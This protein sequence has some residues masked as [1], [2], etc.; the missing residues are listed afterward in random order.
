MDPVKLSTIAQ[1]TGGSLVA[2]K[3]DVAVENVCTDSRKLGIGDLF[4]ALRGE[5]FDA[6]DFIAQAAEGGAAAV[7]AEEL[8]DGLPAEFGAIVVRDTLTALQAMAAAYRRSLSIK[9]VAITGSNGKTSTKDLTASVLSERYSVCKT[10]G[11]LNNH[12]G[13]PLSL[14]KARSAHEYGVF[15]IGM[16]HP[17]EIGPLTSIARP[18]IGILTNVGVAHIEFMKTREAIAREKGMLAEAIGPEGMVILPAEDDYARGIAGRTEARVIFAGIERGDTQA[19][20]VRLEPVGTS[21]T[22]ESGG[23]VA[24]ATLAIPGIHMV[25]NA[26][27]A[28]A[29]G[30][31][32]GLTLQECA[33]GLRKVRLSHGRLELKTVGGI[34]V[35]DDSYNANPDS[36][37]AALE[38][39][40]RMPTEGRRIAV[41][42]RMGELGEQA[43]EG[44]TQVGKSIGSL[45]IDCT[46]VVGADARR[47]ADGARGAGVAEV[48]ECDD[49]AAAGD[50]LRANAVRNDL[51]LVKGS[52]AAR[53]EDVLDKLVSVREVTAP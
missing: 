30:Q 9:V 10:E 11:N 27:L 2:G 7:V 24:E 26:L 45:R 36:M 33:S 43:D 12:I 25:R 52:R 4:L 17:G 14:L 8:P 6:H 22:L 29:A 21:F 46:V 28:V 38:T 40:A 42:G 48:I 51:I 49:T 53:M 39:L 35:I 32:A 16:N 18:D 47:I 19:L 50:W 44:H 5:T 37:I 15:E 13:L 3:P 1:W 31:V 20:D 23:H 34:R 41:L